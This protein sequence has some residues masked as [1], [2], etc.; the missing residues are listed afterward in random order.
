MINGLLVLWGVILGLIIQAVTFLQLQG[1]IKWPSWNK[2]YWALALLGVPVSMIWMYYAKMMTVAFN[3]QIWPQRL[4]GFGLGAIVFALGSWMIFK[5]PL[6]IKTIVCLSL[7][8]VI[9][10]I[11][12]F[13]K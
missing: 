9:V 3:G 2:H 8:L 13:W 10:L 11:Q 7:A 1:P 4:I 12:I 5:E 6:T